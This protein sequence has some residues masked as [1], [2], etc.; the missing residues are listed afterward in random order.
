L[1]DEWV[2]ERFELPVVGV[3]VGFPGGVADIAALGGPL[4]AAYGVFGDV[5]GAGRVFV[6]SVGGLGPDVDGDGQAFAVVGDGCVAGSSVEFGEEVS[7]RVRR[8][9]P[10]GEGLAS[11]G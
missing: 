6:L 3:V 1:G 9:G 4:F 5:D 11:A 10:G 8:E 7:L 2:Q